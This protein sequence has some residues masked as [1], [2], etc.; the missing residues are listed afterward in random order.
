ML[1]IPQSPKAGI[2]HQSI[3]KLERGLTNRLNA[4]TKKGLAYA[5]SIPEEYLEAL[6]RGIA[7]T[8]TQTL[9]ICPHCWQSGT[10]PEPQWLDVRAKYCFL[11][12]TALRQSCG[13]CREPL[14]S[15]KHRFCP[16]CGNPYT[17]SQ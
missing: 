3:G 12:G 14:I 4:K 10:P 16:F 5:L 11:C 9:K 17:Q 6:S 1:S 2:H 7:V 13:S 15:F 8:Q